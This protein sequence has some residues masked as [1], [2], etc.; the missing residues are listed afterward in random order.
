MSHVEN[1]LYGEEYVNRKEAFEMEI[2]EI[3]DK[4][5]DFFE[6]KESTMAHL[7]EKDKLQYHFRT[8]VDFPFVTLIWDENTD[9]P[10]SIKSECVAIFSKY[11][12]E[13]IK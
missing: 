11:F 10:E 6:F 2:Q 5:R 8:K 9:L 12:A 4:Y 3:E 1:Y 13:P 7:T